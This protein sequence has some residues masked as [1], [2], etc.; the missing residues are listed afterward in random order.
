MS[1]PLTP[2]SLYSSQAIAAGSTLGAN[3]IQT[4]LTSSITGSGLIFNFILS[5]GATSPGSNPVIYFYYAFSSTAY[6]D[7]A[8]LAKLQYP[9]TLVPL[10]VPT[11]ASTTVDITSKTIV[12]ILGQYLYT[13]LNT[14]N[15]A[16]TTATITAQTA[17]VDAYAT[18]G[19]NFYAEKN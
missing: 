17:I 2:I 12:P 19:Y 15:F 5:S 6:T 10:R 7:G 16:S 8:I 14:L 4:N 3:S 11:L 9:A 13:W 1:A 18:F